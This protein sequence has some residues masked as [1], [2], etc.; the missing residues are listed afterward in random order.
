M[1]HTKGATATAEIN[2]TTLNAWYV[3]I[4]IPDQNRSLIL[5]SFNY[6][7]EGNQL[8]KDLFSESNENLSYS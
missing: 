8:M 6:K 7:L 5:S 1:Q 2:A 3:I 4:S